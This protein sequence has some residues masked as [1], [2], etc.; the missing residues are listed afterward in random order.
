M[1]VV[2]VYL[3]MEILREI[4]EVSRQLEP[5]SGLN[6]ILIKASVSFLLRAMCGRF[7]M[8][9][10]I[11]TNVGPNNR[12]YESGAQ[13]ILSLR[14][15]S[16]LVLVFERYSV[17]ILVVTQI[18]RRVFVILIIPTGN[19]NKTASFQIFSNLSF[20]DHPVVRLCTVCLL[21]KP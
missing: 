19:S 4:T 11:F 10:V 21:K 9:R 7:I 8:K 12:H 14:Y 6:S 17:H 16:V 3:R 1:N 20:V 2:M 18:I 13:K 15:L 5:A